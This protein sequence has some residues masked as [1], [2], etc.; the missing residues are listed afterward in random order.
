M[1]LIESE[2]ER[3]FSGADSKVFLG[4]RAERKKSEN[5]ADC[6]NDRKHGSGSRAGRQAEEKVHMKQCLSQ[7]VH[8]LGC[9]E[10]SS[11][12]FSTLHSRLS[13]V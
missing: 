3:V 9:S 2:D 11:I 8:T 7:E 10:E 6:T 13:R 4:F 5:R 1:Q 12:L